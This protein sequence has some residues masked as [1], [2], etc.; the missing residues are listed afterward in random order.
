MTLVLA[1]R[2]KIGAQFNLKVYLKNVIF[3]CPPLALYNV[4][5]GLK[6]NSQAQVQGQGRWSL[7]TQVIYFSRRLPGL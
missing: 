1:C 6:G 5:R 7:R 2:V 4:E 3:R